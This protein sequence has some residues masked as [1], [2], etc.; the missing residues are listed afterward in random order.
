MDYLALSVTKNKTII[1]E[2]PAKRYSPVV[3]VLLIVS[4]GFGVVGGL[5]T[6][7]AFWTVIAIPLFVLV[8][9]ALGE[10][11]T[12]RLRSYIGQLIHKRKN[13]T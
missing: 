10:W 9:V 13:K 12:V 1:T 3:L 6:M 5:E 8:T 7:V 2:G 11:I 4:A